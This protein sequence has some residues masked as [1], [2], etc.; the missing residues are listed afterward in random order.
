L[1]SRLTEPIGTARFGRRPRAFRLVFVASIAT[2]LCSWTCGPPAAADQAPKA[3]AQAVSKAHAHAHQTDPAGYDWQSMGRDNSHDAYENDPNMS[4]SIA[5]TLG[6]NWMTNMLSPYVGGPTIAYNPT[7]GQ[8][9]VYAGNY[10]GNL[11]AFN[12]ANGQPVWSTSVGTGDSIY[13][14]PM[15]S[16][17]ESS[18]W[19]GTTI[20]PQMWKLN[21]ATGATECSS[22]TQLAI[23]MSPTEGQ[24][25]SGATLVYFSSINQG[26]IGG[27]EKAIQ[28]SNC[29]LV[30]SSNPYQVP[31]MGAWAS[32]AYG[33]DKNGRELI[34][35]GTTNPDSSE[36][37]MDATT[38]KLDWAY[39]TR[40]LGDYDIG[41]ASTVSAP[42]NNGFADGVLYFLDKKEIIYACDLTTGKLIWENNFGP[43]SGDPTGNSRSAAALD[44][45]T[46]VFG[47]GNGVYALNA[48]T[49]AVLWHYIDPAKVEVLSN[50]AI[51]GPPG[52]EVVAFGDLA[53]QFHVLNLATG[54]SLYTYQ[55]GNYIT[56]S[57]SYV[58]GH[59][60]IASTDGF[61]YDFAAGGGNGT[62]PTTA[63]SSP[64]Q[65]SNLP[66]SST[67]T[68]QGTAAD[69]VGVNAV[70][71]AVQS[72]GPSGPWYN[73]AT[74]SW[75]NGAV[76][77]LVAVASPGSSSSAWSFPIPVPLSGATL[78]V[79]AS[80]V[81]VT[82]QADTTAQTSSFTVAYSPSAPH[83]QASSVFIVPGASFSI[84]GS[85]FKA[86][87]TVV[88]T[89]GSYALGKVKAT[90]AGGV[91]ATFKAPTTSLFG[92][93]AVTATGGTSKHVA[94]APIDLANSWLQAGGSATQSGYENNDAV[95][96]DVID[97][98]GNT[99]LA[100][101]WYYAAG[102]AVES[103]PAVYQAQVFFGNDAGTLTA[104]QNDTSAPIWSYT[105]PSGASILSAPAVDPATGDLTFTAQDDGVYVVTTATGAAVG[106]TTVG[107]LPTAPTVFN[108]TIYVGAD[109]DTLTSLSE[110]TGAVN[111]S[112]TLAG[113]V[114]AT[115]SLDPTTGV[116]VDG[117]DS[118]AITAFNSATG[119]VLWTA[120]TKGPVTA[121]PTLGTPSGGSPTV[122]VGSSDG[123]LYALNEAT[124]A[125]VWTYSVGSPITT[126]AVFDPVL[127]FIYVGAANGTLYAIDTAG[128]Y[129][130]WTSVPQRSPLSPYVGISAAKWLAFAEI[131]SGSTIQY[132]SSQFGR[133]N[134]NRKTFSTLDT[135]PAVNDGTV[136][137]GATDGGVYAYTTSGALPQAVPQSI[138]RAAASLAARQRHQTWGR[139]QSRNRTFSWT[140]QRDVA[141]HVDA[142]KRARTE[143]YATLAY[144]GGPVQ[145][146]AQRYV[147][148]WNPPGTRFEQGYVASVRASM[149]SGS[150]LV[151]S[152]VDTAPMPAELSDSAVQA[153][154]A[155]AIAVN[156]W[157]AGLNAQFVVLTANG[158][159]PPGAGFCSY[160]SAFALGHDQS[161]AVVYA[162]VPYSGA[163]SACRTPAKLS[164]TGNGAVDAALVNLARVGREMAND[165]LL[166]GWHDPSGEELGP[167]F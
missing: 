156:R 123:N 51:V 70:Q 125:K 62:S 59:F 52:Q 26:N 80:A 65:G 14:T 79:F 82:Q 2:A 77:N 33:V 67:V 126:A 27:P 137:V 21:S 36:Y 8:T 48:T 164:R 66:Y 78:Q 145:K 90:K 100:D 128:G 76:T 157:N 107:G 155:R 102:A 92:P 23:Q 94:I 46:L 166:T 105:I 49:G 159:I 28:E 122:Y 118:G 37:A 69:A 18:V 57:P 135:A 43:T 91:N 16:T 68:V 88:F 154:I 53:G 74:N 3:A 54:A 147:L 86:G 161:K 109:N 104:V 41:A 4:V 163:V 115:P 152:F 19:F 113:P 64:S 22:K 42:G 140:G 55:T 146:A 38:G 132:R 83:L 30:F 45:N 120:A 93:A 153:E 56:G 165:P 139:L 63:I 84:S 108:G 85:G 131:A 110:Q 89:I 60:L 106:S 32:P 31:N 112:D 119:S 15:V 144:H 81:N 141:V 148:F 117:D 5:P 162:V 136:Y 151:G 116:L 129:L 124:G 12:E 111:W 11:A 6:V 160:H 75:G 99:Y 10:R 150:G 72:G 158:V 61:L 39:H 47:M 96:A 101:A 29:A 130:E 34:F 71:V 13:S 138:R 97:P 95:F 7:V 98:G 40:V 167:I 143:G 142:V 24:S 134:S 73:V 127:K 9:L 35:Q 1:T 149:R 87:E 114:H 103:S 25:S 58:N 133:F 44:G 50:P 17:D 121:A 20:D